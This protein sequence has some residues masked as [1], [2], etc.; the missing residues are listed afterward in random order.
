MSDETTTSF[1]KAVALQWL[2][3]NANDPEVQALVQA[4][5]SQVQ[6]RRS[7]SHPSCSLSR[8]FR[9]TTTTTPRVSFR[10]ALPVLSLATERPSRDSLSVPLPKKW[11]RRPSRSPPTTRTMR[12]IDSIFIEFIRPIAVSSSDVSTFL[13]MST[14]CWVAQTQSSSFLSYYIIFF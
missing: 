5:V 13:S 4:N 7:S 10:V 3:A 14:I 12:M 2:N 9:T 6:Q 1:N 11:W 8:P